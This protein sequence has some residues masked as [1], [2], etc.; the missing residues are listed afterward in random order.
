MV[1]VAYQAKEILLAVFL[2]SEELALLNA[3][4]MFIPVQCDTNLFCISK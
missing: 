2:N 3:I 1:V 4:N